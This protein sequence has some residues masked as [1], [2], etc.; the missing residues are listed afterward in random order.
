MTYEAGYKQGFEDALNAAGSL[1]YREF[2]SQWSDD[3]GAQMVVNDYQQFLEA[4]QDPLGAIEELAIEE[5]T[6]YGNVVWRFIEWLGEQG[7]VHP[8]FC[9][10]DWEPIVRG[11]QVVDE[12]CLKCD[13][14]ASEQEESI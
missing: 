2:L 9:D 3:P 5:P 13:L 1:P 14:V 10:H 11:D 7:I 6:P 8:A 4:G 12:V